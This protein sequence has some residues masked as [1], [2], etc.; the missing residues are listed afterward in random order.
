MD[1]RGILRHDPARTPPARRDPAATP[2]APGKKAKTLKAAAGQAAELAELQERLF[3]EATAGGGE[4]RLLV[5]LQGM[6][7][8]GKGGTIKHAIGAMNPQGVGVASFKKPTE[9]EHRHHFLWRVRRRVPGPGIVGVFDRSHYE[10]VLVARVHELAPAE[11]IERRYGEINKFEAKLVDA[12]VTMVK[13]FLHLSWAEQ[14]ERLLARLD[15][16]TKRWKFNPAD[17]DER[18][19]WPRYEEAYEI[20]LARCS[21]VAAPW[22][23][24]PADRKWYRNWAV[25]QLVLETLRELDPQYPVPDLDVAALRARLLAEG[26]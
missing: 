23:V 24:V 26:G 5:V 21:T 20:A 8:S 11:E 2:L 13:V 16:P 9:E 1:L 15:D 19:L 3:A 25:G 22:Y 4:R 14:R 6:D 7:T 10:D 17:L 12:G 18:A